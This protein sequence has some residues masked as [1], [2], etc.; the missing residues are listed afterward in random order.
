MLETFISMLLSS[1]MLVNGVDGKCVADAAK[2][3]EIPP[4]IILSIMTVEGGKTGTASRNKNGSYDLGPMQINTLWLKETKIKA[5][6]LRDNGCAN[7]FTGAWILKNSINKKNGSLWEGVA[8]YHS[9][10]PKYYRP[11]IKKV[12]HARKKILKSFY[13]KMKKSNFNKQKPLNHKM[14]IAMRYGSRGVVEGKSKMALI[15]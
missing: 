12:Y 3:Y 6:T 11:Y 2:Y 9:K 7:V 5:K 4:S 10:T 1:T 14:V 8:R 15:D 13:K